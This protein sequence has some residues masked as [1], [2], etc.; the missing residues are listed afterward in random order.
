MEPNTGNTTTP[1]LTKEGF[2]K[3]R[4]GLGK[5][6][7]EFATMLGYKT[8][9]T[10]SYKENGHMP[11]SERDKLMLQPHLHLLEETGEVKS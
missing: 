3:I 2:K 6:Q 4:E 11:I 5:T 10:I 1:E 9:I 7:K 8:G